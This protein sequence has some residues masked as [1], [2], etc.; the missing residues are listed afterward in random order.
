MFKS[1]RDSWLFEAEKIGLE[2][3]YD[4]IGLNKNN[5]KCYNEFVQIQGYYK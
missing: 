1:P 5:L 3:D 4:P 2:L